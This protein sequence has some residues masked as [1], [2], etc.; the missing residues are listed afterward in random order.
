MS[1]F[2]RRDILRAA[3]FFL[4]IPFDAALSSFEMRDD[5][6]FFASSFFFAFAR[7]SK[8]FTAVLRSDFVEIFLKCLFLAFLS[9]LYA[10]LS[11]GN[12]GSY[13]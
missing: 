4:I 3:V 2:I 8:F 6:A 5:K 7:L 13:G 12:V 11:L 1:I 10:V 9:S